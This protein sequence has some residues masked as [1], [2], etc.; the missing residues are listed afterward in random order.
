MSIGL[1]EYKDT[2]NESKESIESS[3]KTYIE[4]LNNVVK[5][6]SIA[7]SEDFIKF[8]EASKFTFS[9]TDAKRFKEGTLCKR[10][11]GRHKFEKRS[12]IT[13]CGKCR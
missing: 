5:D 12:F 4:Y 3:L 7:K 1:P 11:G 13:Y 2:P 10:S 8:C 9:K 6:S